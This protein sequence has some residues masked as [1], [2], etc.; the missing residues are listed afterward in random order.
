[1]LQLAL[2][3]GL[4]LPL[5]P[6]QLDSPQPPLVIANLIGNWEGEGKLFG[7]PA[8][9][10][11]SWSW[12]L[13][14][15]FVRLNFE[16]GLVS[17]GQI[18]PVLKAIAFYRVAESGELTGHWFDS[19]GQTLR[20]EP[21]AGDS[22]LITH[23]FAESEQGRTTYRIRGPDSVEV[24]DEVMADGQWR[25]FGAASYRRSATAAR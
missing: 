6:Q 12:E 25:P 8:E 22:T 2:V 15:R 5:S 24:T 18:Q 7:Q 1:M 23:W 20:L 16:N 21:A 14:R 9:F 3:F 4:F 11:M 17:D 13:D 19:R 10:S